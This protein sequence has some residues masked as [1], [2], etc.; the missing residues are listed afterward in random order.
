VVLLEGESVGGTFL[1]DPDRRFA[2]LHMWGLD[3]LD[4]S[5]EYQAWLV[6]PDGTRV[7]AGRFFADPD[8]WFTSAV[9]TSPGPV[10]EFSGLGVTIEPVGGSAQPTGPRVLSADL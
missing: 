9:L 1:F 4:S 8:S 3:A 5:Q 6:R 10:G 7:S 2:V